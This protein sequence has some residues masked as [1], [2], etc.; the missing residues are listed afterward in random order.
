[1]RVSAPGAMSHPFFHATTAGEWV[2]TL[3]FQVPRNT[4]K[5]QALER[6]LKLLPFHECA[7][8]VHSDAP[9]L[10]VSDTGPIQEVTISAH[11]ADELDTPEFD[12]FLARA[13]AAR[14][15][16]KSGVLVAASELS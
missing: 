8:P 4:F 11:A 13:V 16:K 15:T 12:A 7:V 6:Q 2:V 9:R 5:P 14:L 10:V 1:M 3:R